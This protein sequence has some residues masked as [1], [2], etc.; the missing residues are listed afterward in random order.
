MR[1]VLIGVLLLAWDTSAIRRPNS[2][3][4]RVHVDDK[5]VLVPTMK[6]FYSYQRFGDYDSEVSTVP[7]VFGSK[8]QAFRFRRD[9]LLRFG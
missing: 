8:M 7:Q 9:P 6:G 2:K 5:V 3:Y 4:W 1:F